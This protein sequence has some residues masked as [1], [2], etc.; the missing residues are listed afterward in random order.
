MKMDEDGEKDGGEGIDEESQDDDH[1][2]EEMKAITDAEQKDLA[3]NLSKLGNDKWKVLAKK[4]GYE[5]DEVSSY[6]NTINFRKE[7][8]IKKS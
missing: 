4:L 2:R 5:N 1:E 8:D 3:F 6:V 7:I